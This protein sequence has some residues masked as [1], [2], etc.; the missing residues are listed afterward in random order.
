MSRRRRSIIAALGCGLIAVALAW[1]GTR[2]LAPLRQASL[3]LDDFRLAHFAAPR[4][5]RDDIVILAIDEETL[6]RVP[7]RS[8]INRRLI[9]DLV[10]ELGRRNVRALG[11]DLIFDQPTNAEDDRA[12]LEALDRFPQPAIVAVGDAANGLTARQ[13]AFQSEFLARRTIGLAGMLTTGGVV[14]Y[15]YPGE[16]GA[17]GF[18]SSFAAALAAAAGASAPRTP[19]LLYYRTAAGNAPL[20]PLYPAHYLALLPP[21]RFEG[22]I[23]LIGADLPNQ[24]TFR[25]P[26][27]VPPS[28][29]MM[30]GVVLHAQALGQLLD[31]AEFPAVG[32]GATA[33]I[34]VAAVLAGLGLAFAPLGL[35]PK[36]LLGTAGLTGYSALAVAYFTAG[37]ALLPL[38]MPAAG[39]LLATGLGG[40]YARR[41]GEIEK[42]FIR[43][44]FGRYVSQGLID[45]ILADPKRL[46]LG[47]ER[48]EMSFVFSDLEGFTTVAERLTPDATVALLQDYLSGML[49]IA[50]ES[51]GTIDRVVGDGIAVFFGAPARQADHAAR[52][53][54]CALAWDR[55]S[56]EFRT[57]QRAKGLT[58]GITRIGVH[59]GNAVVGNVGSTDRFHYT[60]HGD[61]V[62]TAARLESAN[63]H[64][65]TRVCLSEAAARHRPS[66][67]FLPVGRLVLKGKSEALAC[68]TPAADLPEEFRKDYLGAYE[69]LAGDRE[70]SEQRFAALCES[71]P[72][73]PLPRLHLTRLRQGAVGETIV[74]EEK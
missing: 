24:D 51:G 50:L 3:F 11:L 33:A 45:E 68:V 44:A 1:L 34:L 22:R 6:A 14:R 41:E 20:V 4:A 53:V 47:G 49:R 28:G 25:T 60:A 64:L 26:L 8:P 74:L 16:T 59:T 73:E 63:R 12:L 69:L 56:Q 30:A 43:E 48:R 17:D 46:V 21:A 36:I 58:L 10:D 19:Q 66:D 70:A 65:G 62:N 61:C 39:F 72:D 7:F 5:Q 13:L 15:I 67:A 27:S 31:G 18:R 32:S 29:T 71:W 38:F 35:W 40:A 57:A 55:Y 37:G 9:A 42:R 54:G 23:V 52:A 2:Y